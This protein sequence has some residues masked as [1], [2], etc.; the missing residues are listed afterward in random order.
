MKMQ[1]MSSNEQE[2]E[3]EQEKKLEQE[4]RI[5]LLQHYSSKSTLQATIILSLAIAFFTF[6]SVL[7]Y[8]EE[9]V[10]HNTFHYSIFLATV[11]AGFAFFALRALGRLFYWGNMAGRI[12]NVEGI[13]D[14][15]AK[16]I[17][18]SDNREFEKEKTTFKSTYFMKLGQACGRAFRKSRVG[19]FVHCITNMSLEPKWLLCKIPKWLRFKV[20]VPSLTTYIFLWFGF[21]F[22]FTNAGIY[23]VLYFSFL[24]L[25][26]V[27]LYAEIKDELKVRC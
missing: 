23:W 13:S 3:N 9:R 12:L 25:A 22:V 19:M 17:A 11:L 18:E 15:D 6:V 7:G 2:K 20:P 5:A 21:Y 14:K 24:I 10:F 16:C 27:L 26:G 4:A 8:L 1:I